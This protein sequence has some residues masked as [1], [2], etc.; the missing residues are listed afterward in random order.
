MKY[1]S[2]PGFVS[3]T[4]LRP[5]KSLNVR[6]GDGAALP[7]GVPVPWPLAT[8]PDGWLS[9]NGAAFDKGKFPK[10]AAVYP[11]GV[12]PDLRGEFIRGWDASRGVDNAR[13]I[14]SFQDSTAFSDYHGDGGAKCPPRNYYKN[15]DSKFSAGAN[16]S[17]FGTINGSTGTAMVN[18]ITNY[19]TFRP[20]NIAFNYIVRAA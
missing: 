5:V 9:Y 10:L 7:V 14:L 1:E 13:Q 20:R 18:G 4:L 3:N 19:I 16:F 17:A 12:L 6:L 8:P 2:P 11:D 15:Q